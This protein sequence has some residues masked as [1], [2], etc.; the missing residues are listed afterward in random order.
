PREPAAATPPPPSPPP[1]IPQTPA[2]APH[3]PFRVEVDVGPVLAFGMLPSV[4]LGPVVGA[5]V[6]SPSFWRAR[7]FGAALLPQSLRAP[8]GASGEATVDFGGLTFCP[9]ALEDRAHR[10]VELCAGAL[11]G[12]LTVAGSGFPTSHTQTTAF[13]DALGEAA[14]ILPLGAALVIRIGGGV[15]VA[16]QRNRIVYDDTSGAA[17]DLYVSP[18]I[19]GQGMAGVGIVLP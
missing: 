3:A 15:A 17:Q 18:L 2:P 8:G 4:A 5:T 19:A 16:A 12:A 6:R 13:V 9:L 14:L 11:V 1:P 10:A 7:A